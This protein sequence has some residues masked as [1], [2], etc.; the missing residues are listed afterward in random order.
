MVVSL[1]L[2]YLSLQQAALQDLLQLSPQFLQMQAVF[3]FDS[4]PAVF[5]ALWEQEVKNK[6]VNSIA[7][8]NNVFI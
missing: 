3:S 4:L 5:S 6:E 8:D 2:C 1:Q 7:A